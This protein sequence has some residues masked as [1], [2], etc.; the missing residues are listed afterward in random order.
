MCWGLPNRLNPCG[1]AHF[2]TA[3]CARPTSRASRTHHTSPHITRARSS[4]SS[5]RRP[6]ASSR[7]ASRGDDQLCARRA[8]NGLLAARILYTRHVARA[9]SPSH[10]TT[11]AGS[12]CPS[13]CGEPAAMANQPLAEH[14]TNYQTPSVMADPRTSRRWHATGALSHL[15]LLQPSRSDRKGLTWPFRLRHPGAGPAATRPTVHRSLRQSRRSSASPPARP[16]T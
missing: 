2:Q 11:H 16:S 12:P 4:R 13:G 3:Q 5:Q 1:G 7:T 15:P 9:H 10:G 14:Q 6:S 8:R